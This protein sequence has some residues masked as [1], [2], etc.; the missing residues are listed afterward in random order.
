MQ[1]KHF[2]GFTA[3]YTLLTIGVLVARSIGYPM[4]E[5]ICK[6][7]LMISLGAFFYVNVSKPLT[8]FTKW[9]LAA[10]FFSWWGDVFL[11]F[12]QKAEI[13]FLLGL[14]AFLLGHISYIVAFG[15]TT[16]PKHSSILK[17]Q[18]WLVIPFILLATGFFYLV[19]DGLKDMLIPVIV[20][21]SVICIM[22]LAAINR[23]GRVGQQSFWWILIGALLFVSSD[24]I[25]GLNKFYQPLPMAG[26]GIMTTYCLAQYLIV[27]GALK[28]IFDYK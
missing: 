23:Y 11:L 2:Y 18:I 13:Y 10:L 17:Q 16:F 1:F 21:V 14:L 20:Y 22:A 3:I 4:L 12:Q 19:W 7:C 15:K 5:Y 26:V 6:P 25:I 9:M 27:L 8:T 24:T 28:Q